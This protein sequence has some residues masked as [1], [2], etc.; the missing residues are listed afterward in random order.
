[1]SMAWTLALLLAATTTTTEPGHLSDEALRRVVSDYV[2][3]YRADTLPRWRLLFL[4]GFTAAHLGDDGVVRQR[5]L[6][7]FYAAQERYFKTGKSIKEDLEN[8]HI[9]RS[10]A[11]ASAWA[12]FVLTEDA[13][14]SRGRLVLLLIGGPDGFKIHSLMFQY[15]R[16][17]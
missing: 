15:H 11:L 12:D 7:E 16:T 17:P 4:P 3:L 2:S 8:V 6:A 10:G 13:T 5:T 1:M 14:R 9:E